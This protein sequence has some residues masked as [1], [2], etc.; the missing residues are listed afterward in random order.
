MEQIMRTLSS[1]LSFLVVLIIIGGCTTVQVNQ[2]YDPRADFSR[3][4]TWQWRDPVQA[5]TGDIRVDNPLLDKRIRR[6]V[7]NHLV[8]RDIDLASG[9]PDFYLTYHLTIEQKVFS[10]TYYST[11]GV[12]S[13]YHPWYGG[14]GT[15]TRIR[16][17]EETRLTIDFYAADTSELIWRGVGTFRLRKYKTPHDAAEAIGSVVDQTLRQFPPTG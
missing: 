6:A 3:Y 15:E 12:G 17:Y 11:V 2:D 8:A 7:E 4:G 14:V 5:A 1:N 9:I 10:D 16:Q 13:Y